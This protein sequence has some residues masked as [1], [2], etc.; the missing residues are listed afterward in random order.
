MRKSAVDQASDNLKML[1]RRRRS[2]RFYDELPLS[3]CSVE[4]IL[5]AGQSITS[6]DGKRTAPSAHALYPLD[7]FVIVRRV[8]G[9]EPGFYAYAPA[10][11][12]LL[13]T[14]KPLADGVLLSTSLANDEWLED[15]AMVV[16]VGARLNEAIGQFAEQQPDGMRGAR[17]VQFEAGAC[18]QKMYLAVAAEGLGAVVVMGFDDDRLNE[19]L[20]LPRHTVPIALFCVGHPK[21]R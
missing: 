17:Y 19:A 10:S 11:Q 16:V 18:T 5:A 4:R 1:L 3:L 6:D 15:A 8:Q 14:G 21:E 2:I 13:L 20:G 9:L 12:Q 7:L